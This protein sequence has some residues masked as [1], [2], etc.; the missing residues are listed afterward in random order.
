MSCISNDDGAA[1][2][3]CGERLA[4]S[5]C[6]KLGIRTPYNRFVGWME[7]FNCLQSFVDGRW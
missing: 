1:I 6:I 2:D 5:N 3:V 4:V 7:V